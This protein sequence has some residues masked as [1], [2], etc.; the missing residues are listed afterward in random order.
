MHG[1]GEPHLRNASDVAGAGLRKHELKVAHVVPHLDNEAAGPT[2]SVLRLCES[3]AL[4]GLSI[5]LHTM[6]AGRQPVG[7]NLIAHPQW[8]A[9]GRFGFS[10]GIVRALAEA[11]RSVDIVH[12]H[13]LWS[14]SNMVAGL[15]ARRGRALLV[16]S[17]RGTLSPEA[18]ARSSLKKW[19]FKP[20]QWPAVTRSALLHATSRMEYEDI[21]RIRIPQPVAIIPNG[22]DVPEIVE[23]RAEESQRTFAR[24]LFLGRLHPIKGVEMLL[25]AWRELQDRHPHWELVVAGGGEHAYVQGLQ[26]MTVRLGLRRVSFPGPVFGP[27]KA[28]LYRASD[29]FVLPTKTENFGMAVAEALAQGLPVVTT[30]RAP[31]PGLVDNRCGWWIERSLRDLVEALDKAMSLEA[32]ELKQMG[33]RG[34]QWMIAEYDWRSI[35]RNMKAVYQWLCRGGEAP[36]CV[37]VE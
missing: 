4:E 5:D 9:L 2:Q 7:V 3:L 12:N 24:M 8:R 19:L 37:M 17:P 26:A 22:I 1:S 15:T 21:R 36:S 34:R 10:F 27:D 32:G 28:R 23:E 6:A 25:E 29:L 20:L 35:A 16:T 31:W 11:G 14:G 33:L 18:R 30:R 13:S